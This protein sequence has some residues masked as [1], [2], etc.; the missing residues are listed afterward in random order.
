MLFERCKSDLYGIETAFDK[1]ARHNMQLNRPCKCPPERDA[2][3]E[4]YREKGYA[5]VEKYYGKHSKKDRLIYR[6]MSVLP[7]GLKG[8]V[9]K[10]LGK[11][12]HS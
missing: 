2:I 10:L 8:R 12:K 1:I 11:L 9:K 4:L 3:M 6:G 7:K 5:A